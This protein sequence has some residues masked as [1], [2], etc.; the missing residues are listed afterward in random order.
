M[1]NAVRP[2]AFMPPPN[3]RLSVFRIEGLSREA[4]W[5]IGEREV[6]G[7]MPQPRTLYGVGDVKVSVCRGLNLEVECDDKP[8]GHADVVGWPGPEEKAK[9]KILAA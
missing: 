6:I 5:S 7:A 1:A 9:Q 3:L 8:P 2:K 4:V